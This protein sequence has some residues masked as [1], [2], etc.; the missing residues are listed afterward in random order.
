MKRSIV[1]TSIMFFLVSWTVIGKAEQKDDRVHAVKPEADLVIPSKPATIPTE[2][3]YTGKYCT[4]CH[5][6]T[7]K[8]GGEKFLK[9]RGDYNLLCR[10]HLKTLDSYI[11][12]T[13]IK[14]SDEKKTKIP[15]DL[16]LEDGRV[17]CLTCH[18]IYLQCQERTF[19]KVSLKGG[20]LSQSNGFL[21]QVP[22][23]KKLCN[24]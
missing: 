24:V 9:F 10:C 21:L 1:L 17:T 15:A 3:H 11:H 7:P 23:S 14:P 19:D 8:R 6:Q 4:E 20:A 18:D 16:P 13:D 22:R 5:E 2:F 12:Q